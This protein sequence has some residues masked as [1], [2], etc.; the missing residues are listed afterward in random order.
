M[1]STEYEMVKQTLLS[2]VVPKPPFTH[3]QLHL[4]RQC[5]RYLR[6]TTT[7]QELLD[8]MTPLAMVS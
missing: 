3:F 8:R 7:L 6:E 4:L 1:R 2:P 5:M